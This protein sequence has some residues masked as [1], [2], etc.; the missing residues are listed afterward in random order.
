MVGNRK[1]YS[2]VVL[3]DGNR[4]L[5]G[6]KKRGFGVGRWNGFGGKLEK[7][8]TPLQSAQ[9]YRFLIPL[10]HR[11]FVPLQ[12]SLVSILP[13]FEGVEGRVKSGVLGSD[14]EGSDR[15]PV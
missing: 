10:L 1:L 2:L 13:F 14:A 8:E 12:Q 5:L 7:K 9:R 3:R 11:Y 4:V 6:L 15:V